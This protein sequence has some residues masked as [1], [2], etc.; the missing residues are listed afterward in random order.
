[1]NSLR[2]ENGFSRNIFVNNH[3]FDNETS[4]ADLF[5]DHFDSIYGVSNWS[6]CSLISRVIYRYSFDWFIEPG[7]VLNKINRLKNNSTCFVA[8]N[9]PSVLLKHCSNK[10]SV[11]ISKLFNL[12]TKYGSF[13]T[14]G[15]KESWKAEWRESYI[16]SV[17]KSGN[18]LDLKNYS[19]I[20]I[21][22][23]L[24]KI[25]DPL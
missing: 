1:M 22:P 23:P 11:F 14:Q 25:F 10:F 24:P 19:L 15:W 2:K 8:D 18:K 13:P 16:T 4:K 17:F 9:V 21:I 6:A 7:V 5:A 3:Y 20:S 12:C